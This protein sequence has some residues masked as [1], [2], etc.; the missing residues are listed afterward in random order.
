MSKK[1]FSLKA[2]INYLTEN[3]IV[4]SI[5]VTQFSQFDFNSMEGN[6]I[7]F[8]VNVTTKKGYK[9]KR[10]SVLTNSTFFE[11]YG[12]EETAEEIAEFLENLYI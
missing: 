10:I 5:K 6:Q 12:L 11:W 3:K 7:S 9:N 2:V 4:E 8:N 1:Y